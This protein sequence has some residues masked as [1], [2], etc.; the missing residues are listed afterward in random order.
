MAGQIAEFFGFRDTDKSRTAVETAARS[1]CPFIHDVCTKSIVVGGSSKKSGACTIRPK[2]QDADE[3]ICCPHRLYADDY[4]MLDDVAALAFRQRLPKFAGRSAVEKARQ[5]HSPTIAVFGHRWGGELRLPKKDGRGNYFVDWIL[6]KINAEGLAED[7]CAIEV[8]TID[9]T[10]NYR[11]SFTGLNSPERE[12]VWSTAGFNWENVNKRI[13]PQIIY[14][15]SVLAREKYC[16]SGLFMVTPDPVFKTIMGRLGGVDHVQQVGRLQ[17]SSITFVSYDFA[18]PQT[19][20]A[21]EIAPL[22]LQRTHMSTVSEVRDA[23][24]QAQLPE[25]NVY[26][27][28]ISEVLGVEFAD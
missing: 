10:G 26:S 16:S 12:N 11:D 5:L 18:L 14:K 3:V 24:N 23:F 8:Q 25:R 7:F 20:A 13:I 22:A 6:V 2:A 21:G 9:T 1:M 19:P 15:G 27:R 17:P 28:A 4:K